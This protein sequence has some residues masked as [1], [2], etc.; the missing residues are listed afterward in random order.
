MALSAPIALLTG[1]SNAALLYADVALDVVADI[2]EP[3]TL[4]DGTYASDNLA[5]LRP[6]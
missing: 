1:F 3:E 6:G 4:M 5:V 2:E